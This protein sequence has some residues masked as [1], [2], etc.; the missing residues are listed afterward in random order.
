MPFLACDVE[1]KSKGIRRLRT[2]G[3]S[4]FCIFLD[5]Q[6]HKSGG[7]S[8]DR[9]SSVVNVSIYDR[10]NSN[11]KVNND[12]NGIGAALRPLS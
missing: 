10:D 12:D 4:E 3:N 5:L 8:D 9:D 11:A 2:N 1:L 6:I 7:S